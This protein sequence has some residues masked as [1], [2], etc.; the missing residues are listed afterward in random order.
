MTAPWHPAALEWFVPEF[1]PVDPQVTGTI[2]ADDGTPVTFAVLRGPLVRCRGGFGEYAGWG[3]AVDGRFRYEMRRPADASD[4]RL[5]EVRAPGFVPA[6]VAISP[7]RVEGLRVGAHIDDMDVVLR[8]AGTVSGRLLFP[9]GRTAPDAPIGVAPRASDLGPAV[10][11]HIRTDREGRFRLDEIDA[12]KEGWIVASWH[13]A[14]TGTDWLAPATP[15]AGRLEAGRVTVIDVVLEEQSRVA[16]TIEFVGWRAGLEIADDDGLSWF[17]CPRVR[18]ETELSGRH[19]FR[20]RESADHAWRHEFEFSIPHGAATHRLVV[21][22]PPAEP[23][24]PPR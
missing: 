20:L 19:R 7:E 3:R 24:Q 14:D 2:R 23:E 5:F 12:G 8:R 11:M 6:P 4:G 1:D 16:L 18:C 17:D 21:D 10:D 9:T 13:D 22:V 15:L